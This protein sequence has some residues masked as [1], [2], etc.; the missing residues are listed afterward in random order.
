[1]SI[2]ATGFQIKVEDEARGGSFDDAW[3]EVYAQFVPNHINA[4]NGYGGPNWD[5]WLPAFVHKPDCQMRTQ[6][7]PPATGRDEPYIYHDCLCGDRAVFICDDLTRKGTERNGQEYVNPVLVLTG[8]EYDA[9][10]WTDM[11]ARIEESVAERHDKPLCLE[12]GCT[13]EAVSTE[14]R[15]RQIVKAWCEAHDSKKFWR[16][17]LKRRKEAANA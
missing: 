10:T 5:E 1:M 2:Y 14:T 4:Q 9:I 15:K 7:I 16:G 17:Q 8:A 11:L 3:I 6:S 13:S 12:P